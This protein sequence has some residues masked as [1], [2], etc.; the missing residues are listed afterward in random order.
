MRSKNLF[1]FRPA[2]VVDADI[3][4]YEEK[5]QEAMGGDALEM[6]KT[7][8][9]LPDTEY[10]AAVRKMIEGYIESESYFNHPLLH[11]VSE[12]SRVLLV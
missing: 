1:N 9:S 7:L 8:N 3:L 2:G 5:M 10:V 11:Q 6:M 4:A 12:V